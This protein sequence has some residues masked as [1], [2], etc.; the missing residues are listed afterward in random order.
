MSSFENIIPKY[1]TASFPERDKDYRFEQLMQSFLKT[2][3]LYGHEFADAWLWKKFPSDKDF[4]AGEKDVGVDLVTRTKYGD[5]WAV[6]CKCYQANTAID[7]PKVDAFL[8]ISGKSFY[9]VN[10]PDKKVRF[11]CR[12]WLDTTLVGF[13]AEAENAIRVQIPEVKRQ[14]YYDLTIVEGLPKVE[15]KQDYA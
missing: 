4:G 9:D 14:G 15:G 10:E 3:P 13:N 7:K 12:L 2:Y 5:Y 8:S 1:H 6:Q 11:S